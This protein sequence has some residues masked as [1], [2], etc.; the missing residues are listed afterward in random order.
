M[1]RAVSG[2]SAPRASSARL[3]AKHAVI[4]LIP[5]L[6]LGLALAISIRNEARARGV[7]EG[8][9]EAALVR[10]TAVEPL[11]DGTHALSAGFSPAERAALDR[12]IRHAKP[13]DI[14][15]MRIRDLAGQVVY[16]DD[17]SGFKH[18]RP[19]DEVI[20]ALH[21]R[22]T[23]TLTHL[24]SDNN[25]RGSRRTAAIEVYQPLTGGHSLRPVGV[26]ELYLPYTPIAA[27]ISSGLHG[28]YV[29][30]A[31][32]LALLYLAL[33][34][35]TASNS[36][37]L[38]R[39]LAVNARQ[40][41]RLR[42]DEQRYRLLFERNPQPML[43]YERATLRIVAVSSAAAQAYGYSVEEFLE[44]RLFDIIPAED[45]AATQAFID[46]DLALPQPGPVLARP[47]RHRRKDGTVFE[48]EVT[49]DD[50][51]LAE[52]QCR[53]ALCLDV[54]ERNRAA[55]EI[56]TARDQAVEASRMKS[57][58]LA[59]MS[60]EIRT[61]M[62]G[63]IGMNELLLGTP[64][65]G[66]QKAYA[67]Q[68]ARSSEQML[69]LINDIL[70][71]SR[72][73]AGAVELDPVDIDLRATVHQACAIAGLQ[74]RG[75]GL[76]F[77]V[78]IAA[79]VPG[80]VHADGG[81]LRQVLLNLAAN[82]VKFTA[83]GAVHV[84]VLA[85]PAGRVRFEVTDTGIGIDPQIL[86][87]MFEPFVQAD[88]STTRLY[89]GTGL[90]LAISRQLVEL[91]GGTIGAESEA[92]AGSTFWFEVALE[93]ATNA[94][95]GPAAARPRAA[96]APLGEDAPL[97][98]VAEDNPV[99]QSVAM[100]MLE[101]CGVRADVV[102]NGCEALDALSARRYD[103]AF[104]DCQ[105]PELDG[106]GATAELRRRE[107]DLGTRTPVIAMT[108]HAMTGDR[109]R[110][111]EA[112]MDDHLV[113]PIRSEELIEMLERWIPDYAAPADGRRERAGTTAPG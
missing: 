79:G 95:S 7:R 84:R 5:V 14:L 12:L 108:A 105:M 28:L 94:T 96:S 74:A 40:A 33:F 19:E 45:R 97:V 111:L 37:G 99:N 4:S 30:L 106:Y 41:A 49:S 68:V 70:D 21:G 107:R 109:E 110:C 83:Q 53:I 20:G 32:G 11:L 35:V 6:A 82:A 63:V 39:Q 3:F 78:A 67:E 100:H 81:R 62:N 102:G 80:A 24:N 25:D 88:S 29:D 34:A 10:R 46:S 72:I 71:V 101:R 18:V 26:L 64:L 60:H 89:G 65:N 75:K 86:N 58:F 44:M 73:E 48:V 17:G 57:A 31:I 27:D 8:R 98:L 66:E 87:R 69:M 54:T 55:A 56:A 1:R 36:R 38:R 112:G 92:G 50:V 47:W 59:N 51:V 85:R 42:D 2:P 93:R 103:A 77:D 15:R 61:P 90:G 76:H 52:R 113:K 91:M 22:T 43:A 23:A 9:A 104:I 16:S 13:R